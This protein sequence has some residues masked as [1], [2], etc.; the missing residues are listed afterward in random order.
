[1]KNGCNR[2]RYWGIAIGLLGLWSAGTS[3]AAEPPLSF[4]EAIAIA[5]QRSAKLTAQSSAVQAAEQLTTRAGEL[6]DPKLTFGI[7]N[8]PASGPDAWNWS[9]DF[10]TMKRIGLI[11]DMV[12]GDKRR[13]RT[14]RARSE[15]D[16]EAA[17]LVLERASLR[18]ESAMAWYET[19]HAARSIEVLRE[20]V[21]AAALQQETQ[22]AAIAGG[23]A[24]TADGYMVRSAVEQARDAMIEQERVLARARIQLAQFVGDAADRPV[25]A[26]PDT[27][28][29]SQ[30]VEHLLASLDRHP[31]LAVYDAREALA[32]SEVALAQASSKPDWSVEF[33]FGQRTPYYSNM[34]TLMFSVDLPVRQSHRQDRDVASQVA[35]LDKLRAQR[36]D[37]RRSYEALVRGFAVDWETWNRRVQRYE[38]V[39]IPLAEERV[40]ASTA[41]YRGSRGELAAVLDARKADAETRLALHTALL[42]R[43]RAW[44]N[45][46]F[47]AEEE[48]SK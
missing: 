36:E 20:L 26:A 34:V 30:P 27:S 48:K 14:E 41:A 21:D 24:S 6:P 9:R 33:S 2:L 32:K 19:L 4:D 10:M 29:L 18:R 7:E 5:E 13:A 23:R 17:M 1:M 31:T 35:Q 39:L 25:G 42:E 44:S 38:T 37:A 15:R 11:Q 47:L 22:K 3:R 43:G 12:N 46:N 8:L 28:R 45:L 40:K 16:V